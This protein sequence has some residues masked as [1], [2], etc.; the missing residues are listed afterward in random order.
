MMRIEVL[1]FDG[2][3]NHEAFLPHLRDLV[4]E[5]GAAAEVVEVRVDSPA[6][7]D[8]KRFLGSPTVRVDGRDVDP[9]AGD[10]TD[11]GLKCRLYATAQGL[12]GTPPD[13]WV[14]AALAPAGDAGGG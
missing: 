9:G 14:R 12:R 13:D 6:D 1:Y 10:R 8:R 4:G 11:Y 5:T 7:A 2:C 3:P